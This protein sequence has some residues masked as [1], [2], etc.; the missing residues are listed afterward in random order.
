MPKIL[1]VDDSDTVRDQLK[2]ALE[3]GGHQVVVAVDGQDG[4]DKAKANADVKLIICDVNMPRMDGL[5]MCKQLRED[6]ALKALP[7]FMLTTETNEEMKVKGKAVGVMAW[8]VKPFN[9]ERMLA[10]IKKVLGA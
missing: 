6:P 9:A 4:L 10:G 2:K 8:M 3:G 7:V 1:I 5:T